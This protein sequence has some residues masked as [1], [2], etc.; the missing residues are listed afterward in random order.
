MCCVYTYVLISGFHITGGNWNLEV[1]RQYAL[2]VQVY[3]I[4]NHAL[5]MSEVSLLVCAVGPP[6]VCVQWDLY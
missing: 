1:G 2:T 4:K 3:D 6:L 5:F